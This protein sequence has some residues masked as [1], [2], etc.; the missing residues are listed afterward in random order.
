M[1][2]TF[3]AA[4]GYFIREATDKGG[5]QYK[6]LHLKPFE[7]AHIILRHRAARIMQIAVIICGF[8]QNG[9]AEAKL[10]LICEGTVSGG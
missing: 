6:I 4:V 1:S 3:W 2:A 5:A 10:R 8:L 7:L 9:Q